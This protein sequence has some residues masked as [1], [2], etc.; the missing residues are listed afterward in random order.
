MGK[1]SFT[2]KPD[3]FQQIAG[4]LTQ[5]TE[6]YGFFLKYFLDIFVYIN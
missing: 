1:L 6:M 2:Y 4:Y 3:T 5:I